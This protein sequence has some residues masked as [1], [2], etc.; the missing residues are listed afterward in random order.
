[1]KTEENLTIDESNIIWGTTDAA[2][3]NIIDL[4]E[5]QTIEFCKN[6]KKFLQYRA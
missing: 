1:M 6:D 2:K 4:F 3:A 5:K